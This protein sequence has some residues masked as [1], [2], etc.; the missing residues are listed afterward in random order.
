MCVWVSNLEFSK[1]FLSLFKICKT[2][3]AKRKFQK[4]QYIQAKRN[5]FAYFWFVFLI[6]NLG[7]RQVL[8]ERAIRRW[9]FKCVVFSLLV[10]MN[11]HFL[12]QKNKLFCSIFFLHSNIWIHRS[13]NRFS[14]T[15]SRQIYDLSFHSFKRWYFHEVFAVSRSSIHIRIPDQNAILICPS[16]WSLHQ[17][18]SSTLN[19]STCHSSQVQHRPY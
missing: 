10:R 5:L 19:I 4:K 14:S 16:N 2:K 13:T 7:L 6:L 8:S 3:F 18:F 11:A 15:F 12:I 9:P 17:S 1:T